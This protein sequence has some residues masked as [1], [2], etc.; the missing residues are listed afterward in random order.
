MTEER[1]ST[2]SVFAVLDDRRRRIAI[3]C[4][5]THRQLSLPDLAELVAERETDVIGV[6]EEAPSALATARAAVDDL[7]E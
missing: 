3:H 7:L 1:P 4:L 5:T 2:D 6:T